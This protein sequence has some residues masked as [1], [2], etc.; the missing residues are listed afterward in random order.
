MKKIIS[1]ALAGAMLFGMSA[2]SAEASVTASGYFM[3]T[4]EGLHNYD[5]ATEDKDTSLMVYQRLQLALDM[6]MGK[7]VKGNLTMRIPH[8]GQY[9]DGIYAADNI[10]PQLRSVYVDFPLSRFQITAGLQGF[11][12][13][14]YM[15]SGV[16]PVMDDYF[17]GFTVS[18]EIGSATPQLAWF[19][20]D[21]ENN[22]AGTSNIYA[23]VLPFGFDTLDLSL[24]GMMID[25][26]DSYSPHF[27][28]VTFDTVMNDIY[29]GAGAIYSMDNAPEKNTAYVAEAHIALDLA[30]MTPGIA[31][32]YG[33]SA[34]NSPFLMDEWWCSWGAFNGASE[35]QFG[36]MTS[37][38]KGFNASYTD[39][40]TT[41]GFAFTLADIELNN[42]MDLNLRAVYVKDNTENATESE[43]ELGATVW[44]SVTE[45]LNI[46]LDG[47]YF[48]P[49]YDNDTGHAA[50]IACTIY[51]TF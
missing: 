37:L 33:A 43:L 8:Y 50:S 5:L 11:T 15:G 49:M 27:Y 45:N 1:F 13:P 14:G 17:T 31:A 21:Y 16:N 29:A 41:L 39:P 23:A 26:S 30:A 20:R 47:A 28:G 48:I 32:W 9:G 25:N 36:N 40:F 18:T 3:I 44:T 38:Q 22:T 34:N 51:A 35:Y 46:I 10:S 19:V 24:W 12:L 2:Q 42:D 4:G 6:D 7:D